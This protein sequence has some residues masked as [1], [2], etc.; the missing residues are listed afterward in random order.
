MAIENTMVCR[1]CKATV[2]PNALF[3]KSCGAPVAQTAAKQTSSPAGRPPPA[4][5]P[6]AQKLPVRPAKPPAAAHAAG[7][8]QTTSLLTCKNCGGQLQYSPG[9]TV[10]RCLYCGSDSIVQTPGGPVRGSAGGDDAPPAYYEPKF[11]A[12]KIRD[13]I[14]NKAAADPA[15]LKTLDQASMKIEG[16]YFPAWEAHLQIHCSWSGEYYV[17]RTVVKYRKAW[18]PGKIKTLMGD[19]ID[20]QVEFQEPYNDVER[21]SHPQSGVHD[22]ETTLHIPAAKGVTSEQFALMYRGTSGVATTTGIPPSR[23]EF[24]V[25]PPAFRSADAWKTFSGDAL[26]HQDAERACNGCC[27][28]IIQ[29]SPIVTSRQFSLVWMPMAVVSYS[30]QGQEYRHFA[31]LVTGEFWGDLPVD[32]SAVREEA[33]KA[34]AEVAKLWIL[35]IAGGLG[36]LVLTGLCVVGA[37][38]CLQDHIIPTPD[39]QMPALLACVVIGCASLVGMF[40]AF[41]TDAEKPWR[42]FLSN[43][44]PFLI[45][46]FLDPPKHME[47][48]MYEGYP[49]DELKRLKPLLRNALESDF[50]SS[51][52]ALKS[53]FLTGAWTVEEYL[54]LNGIE[55]RA[56]TV[57]LD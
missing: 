22:Y 56:A 18:R 27:E 6:Q 43:R 25:A 5:A 53:N 8:G 32:S 16:C 42:E 23:S 20:G 30:I 3:C 12:A 46:L 26:V 19:W 37:L 38:Y 54:R 41:E 29:V 15:G 13:A 24:P 7:S 28:R 49:L 2:A 48:K 34:K 4:P 36:L 1:R 35:K 55:E 31:N 50:P 11:S 40:A 9:A 14:I 57:I 45:R 33:T 17:E 47:S 52:V 39:W 10:V 51:Y 44:Q 21:E